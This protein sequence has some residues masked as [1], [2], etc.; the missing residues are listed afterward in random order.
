MSSQV[1]RY[2]AA[3]PAQRKADVRKYSARGAIF[4]GVGIIALITSAVA[5]STFFIIISIL[6]V[7]AGAW[8][9]YKVMKILKHE[10]TWT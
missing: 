6:I 3:S 7:A 5:S 10:D 8:D 9:G 2:V 1:D 4:A